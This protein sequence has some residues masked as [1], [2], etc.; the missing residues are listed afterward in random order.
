MSNIY[1]ELDLHSQLRFGVRAVIKGIICPF[2]TSSSFSE[3]EMEAQRG[4]ANCPKV[5]CQFTAEMG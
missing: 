5:V 4:E 3:E 2:P 1:L